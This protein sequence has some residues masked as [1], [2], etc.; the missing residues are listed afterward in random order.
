MPEIRDFTPDDAASLAQSMNESEGGWPGGITGG[1]QHTA[2][3]QLEEW[4]R[5]NKITWLIALSGNKVVGVSTLH[6]HWEDPE[7]AYL[8]FLNV[9]DAYRKQ[10][11]GK[12]LLLES[13]RRVAKEGYRRLYLGT[14]AGNLNAVPV[15][16]RTGF[17]WE[18]GTSVWM[19]N[20]IPLTLK[21][22]IAQPFFRK[23]PDWYSCYVREI[24]QKPDDMKHRGLR[25]YD[26]KWQTDGDMLR[27][28]IDR[29]SR[30][31]TLVET[32]NLLVECWI[33]NPDPPLGVPLQAEWTIHNKQKHKAIR[34]QLTPRLP[35]GFRFLKT[36]PRKFQVDPE[37]TVTVKGTILGQ[38]DVIPRPQ[39][40]V[41]FTLKSHFTIDD[42][43][44]EL[45]TGLR[46]K[47]PVEVSTIPRTL[48][49]RPGNQLTLSLTLKSN[50]QKRTKGKVVLTPPSGVK[51]SQSEF[52]VDFEP[53]GFAGANIEVTIDPNLGTSALPI[54]IHSLLQIEDQQ[55]RTR[56]ETRYIHCLS[57]GGVL[58]TSFD[59]GRRLQ[60]HTEHLHFDINLMKG[61]HLD[62]LYTKV[63]GRQHIRAHFRESLGPPFWPSE[64]MRTHFKYRIETPGDGTTR[65]VTW[66]DSE[67]YM[68]LRFVKT[69]VL[70]S[71]SSLVRVDYGFQNTHPSNS[72]QVHMQVEGMLWCA[73]HIHVLPLSD[74]ILREEMVEDEFFATSRE[75]PREKEEWAETWYCVEFPE[76]GEITGILC[77]PTAFY[78]ISGRDFLDFELQVPPLSPRSEVT[79]PPFYLMVGPGTWQH[80]REQWHQLCSRKPQAVRRSMRSERAVEVVTEPT[81]ILLDAADSLSVPLV[82]QHRVHR[83]IDGTL[84]LKP[85]KGWQVTPSTAKFE[86]IER[87][88]PFHLNLT[89]TR[90][91]STAVNPELLSL[92]AK[93]KLPLRDYIFDL[94]IILT[95]TSGKVKVTKSREEE[96]DI[97]VV[98]N[99]AYLIKIAPSFAGSVFALIDKE[100]GIN[101]LNSLFPK[102]GPMVWINPWYGGVQCDP[103]AVGADSWVPTLL[104]KERWTAK[105]AKWKEWSGVVI[106]TRPKKKAKALR[107]FKIELFVLTQLE[108]NILA[109]VSRYT[110]LT[111]AP[112]QIYHRIHASVQP[113]GKM[114]GLETVAPRALGPLRRRRT[115]TFGYLDTT[116]PFAGVQHRKRGETVLLVAPHG[117]EGFFDVWDTPPHQ[118]LLRSADLVTLSPRGK[119]ERSAFL[120]VAK[121]SWE[122]AKRYAALANL[123]L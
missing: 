100:T 27:V 9:A 19:R 123:T 73:S 108:S 58:V 56:T 64:Q 92:E 2:E 20:Y 36:P 33:A 117:P 54:Q 61:A 17:F 57:T 5:Q 75:V 18:P 52:D 26:M 93:V 118:I 44:V 38:V 24:D 103:W 114:T 102:A 98:D 45:E 53:E 12:A 43:P 29:E 14:W 25:V 86:K 116:Q 66:M 11:Y 85:P 101:Y 8:G 63:S 94:P 16:K 89:L 95:G 35:K 39:E 34:C 67:K 6:P 72:Y 113:G 96:T 46:T 106:S 99:S 83:P 49:C 7:A 107:G 91:A 82:L 32:E 79:L 74:G 55:L 40:K 50:L 1:V 90:D 110:N 47:H 70:S 112:R 109:L 81:P 69:Y 48:W 31:P 87:K 65:I 3:R 119:A 62:R 77:N 122:D 104:D 80:V 121:K 13:V 4:E 59:D 15:Y 71:G 42:L 41:A 30:E 28:V 105:P 60:V 23:H 120:V 22:P 97:F 111:K 78:K 21:L 84:Q 76:T 115:K 37:A 88:T 10:G 51:L 68:R